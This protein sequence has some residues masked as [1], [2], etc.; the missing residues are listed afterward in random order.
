M[1][2]PRLRKRTS[3]KVY[4]ELLSNSLELALIEIYNQMYQIRDFVAQLEFYTALEKLE[5]KAVADQTFEEESYSIYEEHY[6]QVR[7]TTY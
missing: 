4:L 3:S 6:E 2:L 7:C 1:L 5:Q